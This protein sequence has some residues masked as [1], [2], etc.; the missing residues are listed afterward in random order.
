MTCP[1]CMMYWSIMKSC[2]S[3]KACLGLAT[4]NTSTSGGMLIALSRLILCIAYEL[5]SSFWIDAVCSLESSPCPVVNATMGWFFLMIFWIPSAILYSR[6]LMLLLMITS[7]SAPGMSSCRSDTGMLLEP[8]C[9]M[10]KGYMYWA[11]APA[12]S[13]TLNWVGTRPFSANCLRRSFTSSMLPS[14]GFSKLYSIRG[15]TWLKR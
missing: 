5:R 8:Y 12:A 9:T 13:V 15:L 1:P 6:R 14:F 2:A 3:E 11:D 7:L 4:I 10:A